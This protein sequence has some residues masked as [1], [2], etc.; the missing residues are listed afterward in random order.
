M[1]KLILILANPGTGKSSSLRNLKAE[2]VTVVSVTGKELPFKTDIKPIVPK[3]SAEVVKIVNDSKKPIVVIDDA[4]YL[5]SFEEMARAN[6]VG[7]T[8]FTQMAQSFFNIIKAIID[9]ES[10]QVFYILAH[11]DT[12]EDG[13]LRLKTTGKMLSEKIVIEGLTNIVIKAEVDEDGEFV[14]KVK[15][16]GLGVKTP[17]G[18]FETPTIPNDIKLVNTAIK[19]YYK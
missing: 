15:T 10:D 12:E 1:S 9:K 17:L 18:M 8:K 11:S 14:F 19:N 3:N 6:E 7:Y 5:L 2:E 16:D 4:N 13:T